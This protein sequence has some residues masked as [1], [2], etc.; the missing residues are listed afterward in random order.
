LR[1][2]NQQRG[3]TVFCVLHDLE[4]AERFASRVLLLEQGRLVYDGPATNLVE[5]VQEKL[6]WQTLL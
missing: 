6:Q 5:T 1:E 4:M 2:R 3:L